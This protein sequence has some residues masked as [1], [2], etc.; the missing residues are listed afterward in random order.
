MEKVAIIEL[1]CSIH[2]EVDEIRE[3]YFELNIAALFFQLFFNF[4]CTG[5]ANDECSAAFEWTSEGNLLTQFRFQNHFGGC[6]SEHVLAFDMF[7]SFVV[8]FVR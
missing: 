2:I 5:V 4:H 3:L 6:R 8:Y 7:E 1:L